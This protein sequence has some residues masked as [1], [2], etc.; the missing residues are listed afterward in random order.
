MARFYG[1]KVAPSIIPE[2]GNVDLTVLEPDDPLFKNIPETSTVWES[3]NDEVTELPKDF[4]HLAKSDNCLI[5]AMRHKEKPFYGLQFHPEVE[6]STYGK[7]MF[8][9]FV[10]ICEKQT[11]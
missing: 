7:E 5:Q 6:H 11:K 10:E 1:G 8:T 3:H 9:N 4:I 2:Y